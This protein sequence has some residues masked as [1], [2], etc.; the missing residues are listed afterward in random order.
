MTRGEADGEDEEE[1]GVIGPCVLPPGDCCSRRGNF[2]LRYRYRHRRIYINY[3]FNQKP[4]FL[5]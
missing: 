3:R 2:Y 1:E 5:L 4:A